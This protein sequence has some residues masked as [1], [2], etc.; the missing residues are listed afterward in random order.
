MAQ[1]IHREKN[2]LDKQRIKRN[3]AFEIG[4]ERRPKHKRDWT[5]YDEE[6]DEEDEDEDVVD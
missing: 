4:A 5:E 1:S 2:R 6:E 3:E